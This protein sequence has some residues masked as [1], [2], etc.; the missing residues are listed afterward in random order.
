MEDNIIIN[1]EITELINDYRESQNCSTKTEKDIYRKKYNI[2]SNKIKD[3]SQEIINK[4][5]DIRKKRTS[6]D[7]NDWMIWNLTFDAPSSKKKIEESL[8]GEHINFIHFCIEK[9]MKPKWR[10]DNRNN[11]FRKILQ[12]RQYSVDPLLKQIQDKLLKETVVFKEQFITSILTH[13]I[14]RFE[15][16]SKYKTLKA[17]IHYNYKERKDEVIVSVE[18]TCELP[19]KLDKKWMQCFNTIKVL[20]K[21]FNKEFFIN[22]ILENAEQ[23][24]N[25]NIKT[26]S[27]KLLKHRINAKTLIV[28]YI[29]NDPKLFEMILT[30][31][32]E[33]F[34]CRSIFC[35]EY[36]HLVQSHW[37]FIITKKS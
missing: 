22:R 7:D 10:G 36:S 34:H 9:T 35:A 6:Y 12:E 24:Y 16:Y 5:N 31:G 1:K 3:I 37:R 11:I 4:A 2:E 23:M 32:I 21:N 29:T 20:S 33:S 15:Y 13:E 30:D 14:K 18:N 25:E 19:E 27:E 26:I 8:D 17:F 28:K